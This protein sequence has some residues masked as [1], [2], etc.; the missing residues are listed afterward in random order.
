MTKCYTDTGLVANLAIGG[1]SGSKAP[2]GEIR[3]LT[4]CW[5]IAGLGELI[6]YDEGSSHEHKATSGPLGIVR[7]VNWTG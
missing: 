7:Y 3:C 5:R 4:V 2:V 1:K 6:T